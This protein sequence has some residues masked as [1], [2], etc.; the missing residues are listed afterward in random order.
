[1]DRK[2]VVQ[3]LHCFN[4]LRVHLPRR[5]GTCAERIRFFFPMHDG[6]GLGHLA[7]V[8]IFDTNKKN[9]LFHKRW[10]KFTEIRKICGI[11]DG[12]AWSV[13]L[14]LLKNILMRPL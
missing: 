1:M 5:F 2:I 12:G 7:A 13:S 8:G 3:F 6:E 11:A 9:V 4:S 14:T 10:D